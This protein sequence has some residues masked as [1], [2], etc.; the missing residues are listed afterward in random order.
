M[1]RATYALPGQGTPL[2][3]IGGPSL[4]STSR[5]SDIHVSQQEEPLK[6]SGGEP[7]NLVGFV[8]AIGFVVVVGSGFIVERGARCKCEI[9]G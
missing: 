9:G 1:P 7:N 4:G 6:G 3:Q 2:S 8:I 5:Q